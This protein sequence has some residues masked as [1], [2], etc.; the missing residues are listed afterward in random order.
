MPVNRK[1]YITE[2]IRTLVV[3]LLEKTTKDIKKVE[4][5]CYAWVTEIGDALKPIAWLSEYLASNSVEGLCTLL[6]YVQEEDW[7]SIQE[8]IGANIESEVK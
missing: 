2:Q 8:L 5:E 4:G 1:T 3:K 6:D 7:D